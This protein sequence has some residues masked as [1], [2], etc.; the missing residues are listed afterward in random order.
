M[1]CCKYKRYSNYTDY[2]KLYIIILRH[3]R[4]LARRSKE[5]LKK[6][7]DE[8]IHLKISQSHKIKMDG[9]DQFQIYW[10]YW[11]VRHSWFIF[12]FIELLYWRSVKLCKIVRQWLRCLAPR[13]DC[14]RD[15]CSGLDA[16][17]GTTDVA[18]AMITIQSKGL[19][20][21]SQLPRL[22]LYLWC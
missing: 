21:L 17:A 5:A 4:Q 22:G 14:L 8:A 1:I 15:L 7:D 16:G 20:L 13:N 9:R 19:F 2:D 11:K 18:L 12:D 10:L 6:F 3:V